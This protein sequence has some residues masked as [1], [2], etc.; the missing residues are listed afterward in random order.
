MRRNIT[1]K[2]VISA[3]R[4]KLYPF[5]IAR[6]VLKLNTKKISENFKFIPFCENPDYYLDLKQSKNL[7]PKT[8][9]DIKKILR[10]KD[11][12]DIYWKVKTDTNHDDYGVDEELIVADKLDITKYISYVYID[13]YNDYIIKNFDINNQYREIKKRLDKLEIPNNIIIK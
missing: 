6:I 5:Q 13:S 1:N 11:Y 10:F 9:N 3:T 12:G 4:N 2:N 8:D 7:K